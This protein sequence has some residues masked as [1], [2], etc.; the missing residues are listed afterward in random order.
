M[1]TR[2][3]KL[4]L[5]VLVTGFLSST[6][7][8]Q[9]EPG[10]LLPS[11]VISLIYDSID[12]ER[13]K[14]RLDVITKYIPRMITEDLSKEEQF[15]MGEVY[16]WNLNP[17]ESD[18]AF[19]PLL[20]EVNLFSRAAWQRVLIIW[21]RGFGK[22]NEAE[23][24]L[25]KYRSA[26][27]KNPSDLTG[28]HYAVSNLAGSYKDKGDHE[29]VVSLV[30]EEINALDYEGA[31]SSYLLLSTFF[32][33]FKEAGKEREAIKMIEGAISGLKEILSKRAQSIPDDD[34]RYT[35]YGDIVML[36]VVTQRLGYEQMNSEFE[37][38]ISS[39]ETDLKEIHSASSN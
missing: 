18:E 19:K 38:L 1:Y 15:Y 17:V 27:S 4:L 14:A 36:T 37:K 13:G 20:N 33:S 2:T 16:F 21:I 22:L 6:I 31:Y 24:Q 5:F 3:L 34:T 8:A 30:T 29:K 26:Y 11:E 32:D 12:K 25:A 7:K 10:K 39:L 28:I 9:E 35:D 23:A